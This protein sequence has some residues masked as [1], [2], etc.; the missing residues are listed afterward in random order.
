VDHYEIYRGLYYDNVVTASAYPEYDDLVGYM[1]PV[2]PSDRADADSSVEWVLAGT[3]PAGT[4]TFVDSGMA[5]RGVYAYEVFAVDSTPL[6]GPAAAANDWALN[7]WLGDVDPLPAY[8]GFVGVGDI[9]QLG[10]AF[11]LADPQVDYNNEV[12]VGPTSDWSGTGFPLTD[13]L[14]DFEDLMI[15]AL[16]YGNVGPVK[17][18]A[19][20]DAT[21]PVLAW[22]EVEE[23]T[24][25][26]MLTSPCNSLKG[27]HVSAVVGSA[28]TI[29]PGVLLGEQ[30][31]P[32]MFET[33][34]GFD[35]SL[36]VMGSNLGLTGSGEIL[37]VV[38]H[39]DDDINTITV[40]ARGLDNAKLNSEVTGSQTLPQV[41]AVRPNYPNPFNPSTTIS[42]DLPRDSVVRVS[43]YD[44][45]G[46]LVRTLLNEQRGAGSHQVEWNGQDGSGQQVAS[47]TYLFR[48]NSG[49]FESTHKM[50]LV[51]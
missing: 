6:Y 51:K 4:F 38:V 48:V 28:V 17:A 49:T 13:S 34:D 47:G 2:R 19:Q 45:D 44:L 46:R 25:A 42:F 27:L 37:R 21:P 43:V 15:F 7:Y 12:D 40:D 1:V 22:T 39:G 9:T 10:T 41:F 35:V 32:V 24:W 18:L 36:A 20:Y 5:L 29:Q 30:S 33:G 8:D 26:L 11:G 14:I 23:G 3:V 16:N 50:L 31:A